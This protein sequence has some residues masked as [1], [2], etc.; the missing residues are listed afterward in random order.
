MHPLHK[1]A[2]MIDPRERMRKLRQNAGLNQ[3][4]F[5]E[6]C[7]RIDKDGAWPQSRISRIESGQLV[8]TVEA[9]DVIVRA[10]GTTMPKFF[11]AR[12]DQ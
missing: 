7:D 9:L 2:E 4:A 8:L 3:R 6:R 5:A 10:L 12:G 11:G 1:V